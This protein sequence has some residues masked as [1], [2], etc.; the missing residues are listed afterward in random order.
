[1]HLNYVSSA[2]AEFLNAL[3][4]WLRDESEV[5]VMIRYS[6]A[7]G[8]RDFEFFTSFASLS[9]RLC[10][11]PPSTSI[12]AYGK[13]QLPLRGVVD[14]RFINNCLAEIPDGKE[15]LIVE[16]VPRTAGG[17][18]WIHH[19]T[20][21]TR[22]ELRASLED[23]RG[24]PVAVGLFPPWPDESPDVVMAIVPDENGVV[25]PGIY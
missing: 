11:L 7:G 17:V 18:S 12:T 21:E 14:D 25:Q 22:D 5:L 13:P 1:M 6:R 15:Y 9:E 23:S 19:D 16:T 24:N 10:Q 4:L 3:K 20:G 2:D 8:S